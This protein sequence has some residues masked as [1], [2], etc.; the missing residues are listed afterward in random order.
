MARHGQ[1]IDHNDPLSVVV[2]LRLLTTKGIG[3]RTVDRII[4]DVLD[5]GEELATL[6]ELSSEELVLRYRIKHD[7]A[8]AFQK[9]SDLADRL[10]RELQEKGITVLLKGTSSYPIHLTNALGHQA[11]PVLF[12]MG[13]LDLLRMRAVGFCGSRKASEKGLSVAAE[14]ARIL[15]M[16]GINVVSGYAHGVDLTAHRSALE[17]GGV[18]TFVL[19][20]GI[21]G[22]KA[23]S[24]V[25][26][27]LK[28]EN[29]LV[30]STYSPRLPWSARQA[31][32][33]NRIICGLSNAMIVIES[34][35]KGGTFEA[36]KTA[37]E[38][39]RPL[40]VVDYAQPAP[41]AS[42]NR[43]FIERGAKPLRR[44][45]S[46]QANLDG[47]LKAVEQQQE[48][49]NGPMPDSQSFFGMIPKSKTDKTKKMGTGAEKTMLPTENRRLIEDY[50]PVK[51]VGEAAS[52]E[53]R[54]KGHISTMHVWRARR[55]L[56]AC[57]AA[58]YGALVPAEQFRPKNGP[59]E[60]RDSLMRAN[61]AKFVDRLCKYP[62]N[63][64]VIK[65]AQRHIL[66][67]HAERLSRE[68]GKK[69][70][71]ED[72]EKGRAPRP[73]VLDMFAGGGA[74]PLEAARLGCES[75]ALELNPVAY[76][77]ELCTITFPQQF[78]TKLADDIEMWGKIVLQRTH[79]A[80]SDILARIPIVRN[81]PR[82]VQQTLGGDKDRSPH[83][84][85]YSIVAYYWTRTI[86]CPNPQCKGTV[87]LYRQTWLRKKPSGYVALQPVPDMTKRVVRFRV[88]ESPS[89]G[90]LGFDPSQGSTGSSTVCP[91]CQSTLDGP[92]VRE[93]G[94]EH[95]FGQQ[96]MCVIALNPDGPGKVYLVDES[97]A[98]SEA[99]YQAIAEQRATEIE[100]ELGLSSLDEEIPPTGNA[101]LATGKS[102]LYGI[103]TFRQVFTP[104]QRYILL[105]MA[106]EVRRAHQE[107]RDQGLDREL[108]KAITTYLGLWLSRLTDRCNG[109]ARWNNARE[110]I[111]SLTSM[112]RFAMTWDFPEVNIFGGG[113]GDAL[114]QLA[115]I[116]ATV[117]RESQ[118]R[119]PAKVI[120]G[121][122]TA[123]PYDNGTFDAVITDP[124]YYDNESYSELSDVCYVWL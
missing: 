6:L 65:E 72:I 46:G 57:R 73:K 117:R 21:L 78:G 18:T 31:M 83:V 94:E 64:S 44:N 111:E 14:C 93:Y 77:I 102:Y 4:T 70:T 84:E 112:K 82:A 33:R 2:V 1:H 88:V 92:Y 15:A 25:K 69:V 106:R 68:T 71:V 47:V 91:F 54:S 43:Y 37:L 74:I 100:G 105:T 29:Y 5:R 27:L 103:R 10:W 79:M 52:S 45:R 122:A 39:R 76:L 28:E 50:L 96:L 108:A 20:E 19:A 75:H 49:G 85:E 89:E 86:P 124:P 80:V 7:V 22:F 66:E 17:A 114:S 26:D 58:V 113:S 101:G 56:V 121:S 116:T 118:F 53:P 13:N 3:E 36:G 30:V 61:A 32:A 109:L 110:T 99:Q 24:E 60:K 42:G 38:L 41:S 81:Q 97:L 55:P 51:L 119:N 9:S 34:G 12:V 40:F 16:K 48:N 98:V 120:R 59:E 35:N 11:P 104:R 123:L 87:P 115:F 23:K 95:G 90:G 67:A 62:G 8:E 63:P 107:M